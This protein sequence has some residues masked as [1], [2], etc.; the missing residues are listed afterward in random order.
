MQKREQMCL[1]YT[2]PSYA[3]LTDGRTVEIPV[4][5]DAAGATFLDV[6]KLF[7]DTGICTFDPG[8]QIPTRTAEDRISCET[9]H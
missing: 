1:R 3:S 8:L 5:H 7:P 6:R 9:L 4:L 2:Q